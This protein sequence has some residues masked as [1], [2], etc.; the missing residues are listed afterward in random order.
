MTAATLSDA[1]SGCLQVRLAI[2]QGYSLDHALDNILPGI[3]DPVLRAAVQST[4]Y[5]TVR[6][7]SQTNALISRLAARQP[8][9]EVHA[10]LEVALAR[11]LS[12]P[13][14]DFVTVDQ[15]V[16]CAR[17]APETRAASGFVN[18]VL[19]R[20]GR[21]RDALTSWLASLPSA[22]YNA[23]DWWLTRCKKA[24]G[25][26][27]KQVMDLQKTKAPLTLRVNSRK[28]SAEAYMKELEHLGI[29]ASRSGLSAVTLQKAIPVADIP[30]F[31]SGTV[32]V[33]DA[34]SQLAAQLLAPRSG[35]KILDACAAPGGKTGH[36]LEL[37]DAF[38]TALDISEARATG[39]LQNLERLGLSKQARIRAADAA[40][41]RQWWDGEKFDAI[42]LD[43]PCSAS[44]VVRRHPDIP[45]QR[46][47]KDI[48]R[49]AGSQ[50]R[51]LEAVWPLLKKQGR[52]LYCVCSI[53]PE[54]GALQIERFL[55]RHSEAQ[56]VSGAMRLLPKEDYSGNWHEEPLVHDGFFY[57]LLQYR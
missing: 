28:T 32:S 56:C 29:A 39:I 7:L 41:P 25:E 33:Q 52:L 19:R 23:P 46:T 51:I 42:L 31:S 22:Q 26:R 57:A 21:E 14:K 10:L 15:A 53:F 17:C 18:A 43:A 9:P 6:R 34:G 4:A 54:E 1:F 20:F 49:L 27:F 50:A 40:S 38:V 36:L 44:G 11:M 12:M 47:E 30:G 3:P 24:L 8:A 55:H 5:D 45:W 37:A 35:E 2:M 48:L 13:D 16:R